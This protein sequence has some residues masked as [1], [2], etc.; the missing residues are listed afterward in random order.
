MTSRSF[1][2]FRCWAT[3]LWMLRQACMRTKE[4][5]ARSRSPKD[6]KALSPMPSKPSTLQRSAATIRRRMPGTSE[7]LMAATCA[8]IDSSSSL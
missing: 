6:S 1:G 8:I 3:R 7:G 2:C 5:M 4:G